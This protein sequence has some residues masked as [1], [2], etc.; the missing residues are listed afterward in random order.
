MV[1]YGFTF[2][3]NTEHKLTKHGKTTALF[4]MWICFAFLKTIHYGVNIPLQGCFWRICWSCDSVTRKTALTEAQKAH[5]GQN[6]DPVQQVSRVTQRAQVPRH[7][8]I[9]F[10]S[11]QQTLVPSVC[12]VYSPRS[13]DNPAVSH[14]IRRE[15]IKYVWKSAD[16]FVREINN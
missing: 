5:E 14:V 8:F 16:N 12:H 1:S 3:D 9:I 10:I 15:Q 13:C 6:H 7:I 2:T 11:I 4:L